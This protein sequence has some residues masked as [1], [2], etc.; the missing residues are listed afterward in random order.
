MDI[1]GTIYDDHLV[2]ENESNVNIYGLSGNDWLEARNISGHAYLQGDSGNDRLEVTDA[3]SAELRGGTGNDELVVNGGANATLIGGLGDDTYYVELEDF[4]A[5]G[6]A[7][8]IVEA[9]GEGHD[10][11]V[12]SIVENIDHPSAPRLFELQ[13]GV[14]DFRLHYYNGADYGITV[15]GNSAANDILVDNAGGSTRQDAT[16]VFG[17]EGDD[18]IHASLVQGFIVLSGGSG[19]DQLSWEGGD[20]SGSVATLRGGR[21]NDFLT[22]DGDNRSIM[23]GGDGVDGFGLE[24]HSE[25]SRETAARIRDFDADAEKITLFTMGGDYLGPTGTLDERYFHVGSAAHDAD[26]R[27]IFN[28]DTGALYYDSNG[29]EA[30]ERSLIAQVNVVN[31]SVN[32][33]DFF[34]AT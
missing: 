3:G 11:L 6:T 30:G 16:R 20:F 17:N 18:Y 33:A 13:D 10:T 9:A 12:L 22:A 25:R 4:I 19:N 26:D 5:A 34:V 8:N 1:K 24:L 14:E 15:E 7:P 23:Y 27:I 28:A 21:G 29:N 32:A 2:A 31:G